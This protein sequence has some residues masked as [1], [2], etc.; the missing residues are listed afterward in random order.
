MLRALALAAIV[1]GL[2]MVLPVFTQIIVD[3]VVVDPGPGAA[4]R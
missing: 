4:S 1:S 2:Q 3:R